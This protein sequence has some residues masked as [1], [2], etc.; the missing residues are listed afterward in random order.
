MKHRVLG[1]GVLVTEV[2]AGAEALGQAGVWL[3]EEQQEA[4]CLG[5]REWPGAVTSVGNMFPWWHEQER[6]RLP[7]WVDVGDVG[8]ICGLGR[9]PGGGHGNPLQ[10]SCL[11]N[12]TDRGACWDTVP[13]VTQSQTRLK[14]LSTHQVSKDPTSRA[15]RPSRFNRNTMSS[16]TCISNPRGLQ[17]ADLRSG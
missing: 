17:G 4:G 9:S 7:V 1:G 13:R 6:T 5:H 2:T 3:P 10:Y 16:L 15:Y 11:E 12:L 8:L 14:Q